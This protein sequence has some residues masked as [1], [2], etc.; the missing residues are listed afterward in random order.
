[1]PWRNASVKVLVLIGTALGSSGGSALAGSL[2]QGIGRCGK[3]IECF[4][5][6]YLI[7]ELGV[8]GFENKIGRS[9]RQKEGRPTSI[10]HHPH[11]FA[12]PNY[13]TTKGSSNEGFLIHSKHKN[14]PHPQ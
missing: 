6:V 2:Q 13:T 7:W 14:K 3:P 5:L 10:R 8:N 9:A 1:V 4:M 12:A 11:P